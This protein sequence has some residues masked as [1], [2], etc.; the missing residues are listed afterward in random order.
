MNQLISLLWKRP[1][2]WLMLSILTVGF[3]TTTT[4]KSVGANPPSSAPAE[5]KKLLT[6]I[7]LAASRGDVKAVMQFYAPNFTHGDGLNRQTIEQSLV[8]FWKKYPKLKYTTIL[9]SWQ[10]EG[11]AIVTDTVTKITTLP[12]SG[13]DNLALSTTIRSR[14]RLVGGKIVRQEIL[15]E[16]TQIT[17]GAKPPRVDLRV[18]QQVK[19]GQKYNFD[20]IVLEP[21]GDDYLLGAALEEPVQA[22][23]YLKPT[24]VDLELLTSG[25]LFKIGKAPSKPGSQWVSAVI[26]GKGGTTTITE[27][28]QIVK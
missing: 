7:D 11:K 27:R 14:Q 19:V 10:P 9:Q 12:S 3:T 6:Q 17:S 21:L 15:S 13:N 26:L 22:N 18:P 4:C 20:A 2:R 8:S 25:G 5:V 23:K 24:S 1:Y 28:M 16:R